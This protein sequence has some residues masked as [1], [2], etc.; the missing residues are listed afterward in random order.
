MSMKKIYWMCLAAV[1][2]AFTTSCSDDDEA[3]AAVGVIS[4]TV[5]PLGSALDY[6]CDIDQAARKIENTNDSVDWLTTDAA[7][8][9]SVLKASATLGA[10]VY[11]NGSPVSTDGVLVDVTQPISIEARGASS[12]TTYVVNVV[13]A[14]GPKAGEDAFAK[15]ASNFVGFPAGVIDYDIAYFD[16]KFFATVT[17]LAGETEKYQMFS[18]VDGINWSEVA[19]KADVTGVVLPEGQTS[20]VIGGEGARLFVFNDRL[21]VWGGARTKG[22][23]IYG[24]AAEIEDGW[25]GPA[26]TLKNFRLFSTADGETFRCDTVGMSLKNADGSERA[27]IS[28][29]SHVMASTMPTV[30]SLNGKLIAYGGFAPLMGM[31]QSVNTMY[32]TTDCKNWQAIAPVCVDVE[33]FSLSSIVQSTLFTFQ[34]KV[35]AMGGAKYGLWSASNMINDIYSTTDGT[36]WTKEGT[37]PA[38]LQNIHSMKV[39]AANDV[40]YLFGGEFK[41]LEEGAESVLN[42]K[43]Y[44]S[45]DGVNWTAVE[46]PAGFTARRKPCVVA[47]GNVAWIFGGTSSLVSD[48][49]G[50]LQDTDNKVTDTWVKAMN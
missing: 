43:V 37:L 10:T 41:A 17:S 15:K 1:C 50:Y 5:T 21:Y 38:E 25:S 3:P 13:K 33:G 26:P 6:E 49:Y 30:A 36:N 45:T 20:Y 22:A 48:N 44:R 8:Q 19:Y 7:M 18:S 2:G 46:T 28:W 31:W 12:T 23:D 34:N 47:V 11:Y 42:D 16:G 14:N 4:L 9:Q 35:W 29:G 24:N 39:V 27:L 32:E 40:L